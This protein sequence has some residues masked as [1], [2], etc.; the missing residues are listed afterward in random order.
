M[1]TQSSYD[2]LLDIYL[3]QMSKYP[4]LSKEEE[5]FLCK[6]ISDLREEIQSLNEKDSERHDYLNKKLN[7]AKHRM[8][9]SNLRIVISIAR[10]IDNDP[11]NLPERIGDGNLGLI[12]A[13]E[14]FDHRRGCSFS[15]YATWWIRQFIEQGKSKAGASLSAPHY[16]KQELGKFHLFVDILKA[17]LGHSPNVSEIA[18]FLSISS[19]RVYQLLLVSQQS[20]SIDDPVAVNSVLTYNDI[21]TGDSYYSPSNRYMKSELRDDLLDSFKCLASREVTILEHRFGLNGLLPHTLDELSSIM[22]LTRERVRQLQEKALEKLRKL[23]HI[24]NSF[25]S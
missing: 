4:L 11:S 1:A 21:L 5:Y 7:S 15:T 14:R 2:N 9:R 20:A 16:L 6:E 24:T 19:K 18:K 3:K 25:H 17:R 13:V 10:K 12:E 23:S 22:A 8:T